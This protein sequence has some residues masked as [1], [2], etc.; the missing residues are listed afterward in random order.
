[1]HTQE[2]KTPRLQ[3]LNDNNNRGGQ[4]KSDVDEQSLNAGKATVTLHEASNVPSTAPRPF[5]ALT[6][7]KE[8]AS[9]E[10]EDMP[11]IAA[12]DAGDELETGRQQLYNI[13]YSI[14]QG[15]VI[16]LRRRC[17]PV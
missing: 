11:V 2:I 17:E 14:A 4:H 7:Q 6:T 5:E 9:P 3:P 15:N 8:D 12:D 13:R 1:M 16:K 10:Q